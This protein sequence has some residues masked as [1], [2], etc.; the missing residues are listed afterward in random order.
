MNNQ[1]FAVGVDIGGTK[2]ASILV[3]PTG[4]IINSDYRMTAADQGP[5]ESINRV[6]ESIASVLKGQAEVSGIGIDVPGLVF[7]ELGIVENAVNLNWDRVNLVEII[8]EKLHLSVP[9]FLQRD[10]FAQTLGEHYYGSALGEKDYVYLGIGSGLGAGALINGQL[11]IGSNHGA[12]EVGHLALTGLK[13]MCGCGRIGCAET[14]LSGPGLLKTYLSPGWRPDV[15]APNFNGEEISVEKVIGM[16]RENEPRA[17]LLINEFGRYLGELMADL[18]M[19]L[20]PSSIVIGGGVG[21]SAFELYLDRAMEE[22]QHRCFP[23]NTRSL[24]IKK[25]SLDSSALGAASLVWYSMKENQ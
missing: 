15:K 17:S 7:P 19:T 11:L 6:V 10:T 14:L 25:S 23:Q 16:A 21:I 3:D 4:Q 2:I 5:Q 13:N 24:T 22:L 20:N 9:I 8:R 18:V 1:N 12:L